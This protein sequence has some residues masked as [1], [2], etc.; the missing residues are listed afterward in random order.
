MTVATDIPVELALP[1][2]QA[3]RDRL[4]PHVLT[5]PSIYWRGDALARQLPSGTEV[6]AKLELFQ[7]AGTFKPRGAMNVM[8]SLDES[9]RERG[10]TAVSAG[11]HAIATAY[12]AAR[13]GVAARVFMPAF[14][15]PFRIERA[16]A[17][18]ADVVLCE[19]QSEMFE[20][21]EAAQVQEGRTFI[22]PFEGPLT[23]QGTASVGLE[24]AEQMPRLDAMIVPIG[25]GGLAGGMAAALKQIWPSMDVYGVEPE[26]ANTMRMSFDQGATVQREAVRSIA[27]SLCPPKSE[28]FSFSVCRAL[29]TDI[30]LVDDEA[31]RRAMRLVL[32]DAQLAVEPAAAASMAALCGPLRETLAGKRVGTICCGTN[33]AF[34]DFLSVLGAEAPL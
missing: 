17:L 29:L 10:V 9:A 2:L 1:T 31:I 5:T 8:L 24:I 12:C 23:L 4:A 22:H 32:E 3:T 14:A 20:R 25:G 7:Q 26:G 33:M 13:L 18:G 11:N 6:W 19:T 15:K 30:V 16:R 27:D 21:A 34:S 28:P